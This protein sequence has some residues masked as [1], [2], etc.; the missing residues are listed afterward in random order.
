MFVTIET[1]NGHLA[2]PVDAILTLDDQEGANC[3]VWY[4]ANGEN[5]WAISTERADTIAT[6]INRL[7]EVECRASVPM[8]A[9]PGTGR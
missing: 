7:V 3:R 4:T 1:T 2:I 8:Y 6:R 9:M 5:H